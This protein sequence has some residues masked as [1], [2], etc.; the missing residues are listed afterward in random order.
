[1]R[2]LARFTPSVT[3]VCESAESFGHYSSNTASIEIVREDKSLEEVLFPIPA[4]SRW[5]SQKSR[6]SCM[7]EVDRSTP[8]KRVEDFIKRSDGL[9]H[10]MH[11]NQ[12]ISQNRL[13]FNLHNHSNQIHQAMLVLGVLINI[14]IIA[15]SLPDESAEGYNILHFS[16]WSAKLTVQLLGISLLFVGAAC[17]L[18]HGVSTLPLAL[19]SAWA[20]FGVL[21]DFPSMW[22]LTI[23][24]AK[25][26]PLDQNDDVAQVRKQHSLGQSQHCPCAAMLL[27]SS[28]LV[29]QCSCAAMLLRSSAP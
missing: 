6:D 17:L 24:V 2:T 19:R 8:Q 9:T 11:H 28:G 10:E 22:P 20:E 29:Q 13:F 3:A 15:T 27:R 7:W 23:T 26:E 25:L 18:E 4:M 16:H 21:L 14:V 5:L 1:M 12:R